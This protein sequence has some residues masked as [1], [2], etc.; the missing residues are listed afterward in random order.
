MFSIPKRYKYNVSV[1][2]TTHYFIYNKNIIL[3]GQNVST[4][5]RSSSGPPREQ[6]QEP[7]IFQWRWPNKVR[8]ISPWQ[9]TIF[10][11]YKIMCC[12]IDWDVVFIC[13]YHTT[14]ALVQS[15]ASTC[16]AHVRFVLDRFFSAFCRFSLSVS[17]HHRSIP[18]SPIYHRRLYKTLATDSVAK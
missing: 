14:E 9:Y 15:Q 11:V 16:E 10:I 18:M 3:S 12:V 7:F 4:F 8:K 6:I 17:L 5:I 13:L 1:N 2:N